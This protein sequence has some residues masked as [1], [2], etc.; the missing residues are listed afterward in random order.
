VWR[1]SH[2]HAW[3]AEVCW[4]DGVQLNGDAVPSLH[5]GPGHSMQL[6]PLHTSG[7]LVSSTGCCSALP[8]THHGAY[9]D[10][11]VAHLLLYCASLKAPP[12]AAQGSMCVPCM[13]CTQ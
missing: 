10:P 3:C 6:L 13:N 2:M 1:N 4:W 7:V 5:R 9:Q 11:L 12:T 8:G